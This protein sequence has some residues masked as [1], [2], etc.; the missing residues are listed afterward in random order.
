MPPDMVVAPPSSAVCECIYVSIGMRGRGRL[1]T[2]ELDGMD[3]C[4]CED[5][6]ERVAHLIFFLN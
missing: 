1:L 4:T 6:H 2:I 5:A 3:V